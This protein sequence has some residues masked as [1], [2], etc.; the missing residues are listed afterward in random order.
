MV[1]VVA[2]V[3]A[4]AEGSTRVKELYGCQD[5]RQ[6]HRC[7][8]VV[9]RCDSRSTHTPHT[10]CGALQRNRQP[11][12]LCSLLMLLLDNGMCL[13]DENALLQQLDLVLSGGQGKVWD[14]WC[15]RGLWLC[16]HPQL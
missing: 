7:S 14:D 3:P 2:V 12:K 6:Q 4:G 15:R 5:R 16:W 13:S 8:V 10:S 11:L 1:V 9:G